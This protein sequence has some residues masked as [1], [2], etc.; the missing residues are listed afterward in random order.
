[1]VAGRAGLPLAARETKERGEVEGS[2]R[3]ESGRPACTSPHGGFLRYQE[4]SSEA[5]LSSPLDVAAA[6]LPQAW[7]TCPPGPGTAH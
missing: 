4:L 7:P 1:M 6:G 5:R 2:V 3:C